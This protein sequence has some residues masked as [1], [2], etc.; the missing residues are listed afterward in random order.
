MLDIEDHKWAKEALKN[1]EFFEHCSE[2]EIL[3]L[4]ENL[5]K[6]RQKAESQILFMG[7]I[8]NRLYIVQ[9]GKVGVWKPLGGRK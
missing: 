9:S 6:S 5:E 8:S 2:K 1:M 7:E 4:T 3:A